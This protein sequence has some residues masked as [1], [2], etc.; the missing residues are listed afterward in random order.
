M[1]EKLRGQMVIA[2]KIR[3][4]DTADVAK[5]V[6]EKHFIR[7]TKGNLR[8][9][10]TQEFR[11]VAC[12][13]KFRR[14]PLIGKCSFCGGKIL[15]TIT[16]GS[17]VKYLGPTISLIDKYHLSPYLKQ[18]IEILQRRVE[19]VFGKDAEK[20]LGLGQWFAQS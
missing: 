11:C 14:P 4:V 1:E 7:D 16:E 13:E 12:N 8:K 10:S 6:I 3:A 18:S 20:Q 15:F 2:E 5:L 9:F 19:G 17:V